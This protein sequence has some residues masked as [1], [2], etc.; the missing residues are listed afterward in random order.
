MMAKPMS[1]KD[2]QSRDDARTLQ[3]AS[4][5]QSDPKRHATAK[6]SAKEQ[7]KEHDDKRAHLQAVAKSKVSGA[8][9]RSQLEKKVKGGLKKAF[10][11]Y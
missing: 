8:A 2:Y 5:I 11:N 10:P 1:D 6:K 3:N 7:L 4:E 9:H